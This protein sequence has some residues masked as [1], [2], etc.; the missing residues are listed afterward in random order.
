MTWQR[1]VSINDSVPKGNYNYLSMSAT[2]LAGKIVTSISGDC[3]YTI[4]GFTTRTITFPP[5]IAIMPIGTYV[6][7]TSL[8]TCSDMSGNVLLYQ[9]SLTNNAYTYTIT[10]SNGVL[11]PNGNFVKLTD[12]SIISA[13]STGNYFIYLSQGV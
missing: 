3:S 10:D 9:N 6:T 7:N 5:F 13:N 4:A 8:L 12:N 11:N 1:T 2:N